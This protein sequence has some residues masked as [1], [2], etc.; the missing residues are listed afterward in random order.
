MP[1]KG[2]DDMKKTF[3][4]NVPIVSMI[5][6]RT[7]KEC[8]EKINRSNLDG[9]EAFGVQLCQL[10]KEERTDEKL[11]SIFL[12]CGDKPIY[13]TSYRYNQSEG[14]SD[15]ECVDLLIKALKCGATLCDIPGDLFD[16]NDRQITNNEIAKSKQRDLIDEI[17]SLGGE[18]LISTHDF[19][20]LSADEIFDIAKMQSNQGADV[21]KIVVSSE[22]VSMLPE[23]ISVIQRVNNEIKK[24]FLFLDVGACSNII[25]KMGGFLGACMYLCVESH[26]ELDTIYQ[27]TIKQITKIRNIMEENNEGNN[28]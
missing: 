17:H 20:N 6:C 24:P 7:A 27:P 22:S 8:I 25:R 18:V 11:K 4:D 2:N 9:A 15:S 14:M 13:I 28:D 16:A 5:Q 26:G 1:C 12:A 21:L 19:K 10:K 3:L 23:Y